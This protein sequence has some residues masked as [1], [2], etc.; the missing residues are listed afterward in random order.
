M[1]K[2]SFAIDM[3]APVILWITIISL[4]L[5]IIDMS[6][7]LSPVSLLG[8]RRTSLAD[9]MQYVRILTHIV[10]HAD[11]SH[12]VSNFMIVWQ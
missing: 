3:N 9:P 8:A 12:F 6:T 5:L 2:R 4:A 11:L 1:K 7:G 10:V